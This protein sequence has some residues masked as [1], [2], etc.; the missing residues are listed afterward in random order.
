MKNKTN[1]KN[2]V[3]KKQHKEQRPNLVKNKVNQGNDKKNKKTIIKTIKIKYDR[4]FNIYI[5]IK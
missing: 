3:K 4:Y 1:Q 2:N 5:Y